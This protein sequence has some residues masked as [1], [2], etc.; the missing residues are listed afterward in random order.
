[1]R[2]V[3]MIRHS[4]L[5][6]N[7]NTKAGPGAFYASNVVAARTAEGNET[8]HRAVTRLTPPS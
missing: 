5:P 8:S 6:K 3:V 7:R 4:R 2:E 1:M